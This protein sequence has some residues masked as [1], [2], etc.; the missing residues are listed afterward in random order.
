MY[1]KH[2]EFN[3]LKQDAI[4]LFNKQL[5]TKEPIQVSM[6]DY[7]NGYRSMPL[8][9]MRVFSDMRDRRIMNN[10]PKGGIAIELYDR[11]NRKPSK[12]IL[13]P[14]EEQDEQEGV[15]AYTLK[16][17][18]R[19]KTKTYKKNL[20]KHIGKKKYEVAGRINLVID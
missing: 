15:I 11:C 10:Y 17:W 19:V 3:R 1:R 18:N 14:I 2:F 20:N 9:I 6:E 7:V 5:R 13:L 8:T 16:E 4:D 12:G